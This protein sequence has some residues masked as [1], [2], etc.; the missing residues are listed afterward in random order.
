M[1]KFFTISLFIILITNLTASP[2]NEETARKAALNFLFKYS[3]L[4][5]G[6]IDLINSLVSNYNSTTTYFVF[7]VNGGG[8]IL[9][10]A[11]DA[12]TPVLAYSNSG[13]WN[14]ETVNP[15]AK[16]WIDSYNLEIYNAIKTRAT[17]NE[18]LQE[19]QALLN[20]QFSED[21]PTVSPLLTTQW[22]QSMYYN[23]MCPISSSAPGGYGGRVPTG[24]VATTMAQIMK[25]YNYPTQG[26]GS[27]SYNH[28]AYNTLSANFGST[29]Y[30]WNGMPTAATSSN[31]ALATL[32]FHCGVS[33]QM[34]YDP[35]GSGALSEVVPYAMRTYF[36]YS[37][38]MQLLDKANVGNDEIWRTI[39]KTELEAKRPVYYAG[40][41]TV[42]G[43]AFV[44]D[45]FDASNPTKFHINWGW[46]GSNNGYFAIGALTT[47][48]G[49][50]NEFNRI[51]IGI[52]P[53]TTPG[54]ICRIEN[55]TDGTKVTSG[56]DVAVTLKTI[57]G[58]TT[59]AILY[60]DGIKKDSSITAPFNFTVA[61]GTLAPGVHTLEI[62]ATD[63]IAWDAHESEFNIPSNSW[64]VQNVSFSNDSVRIEQI[65][66]VDENVVWAVIDD[67]SSKDQILRKFI[68][69]TDGGAT[70][71]EGTINCSA[72]S[73][74]E[75]SNIYAFS[76]TKAYACL[77]P[78]N[79]KGGAIVYTEDGGTT[80]T[81]QTTANFTS[82]WANWVYFF[83]TNNGVCMGDSYKPLFSQT[84]NFAVFATSNGGTTWNKV[85]GTNLP[86][87]L[88]SEAGTVNFF[89]AIGNTIWFGTGNGRV[90]KST[91]KGVTWAVKDGGLG[92]VQ[93]NLRFRD[94]NTGFA[95]G[96]FGSANY[97][98]KKTTDG[99]ATWADAKPM[100]TVTGQDYEL[101]PGTDS[102]W[103]NSGYYSSVSLNG[104]KSYFLLDQNTQL[105]TARFFSPLSGWGG[106][107]YSVKGGG[108]IYKWIGN[109]NPK[110]SSKVVIRVKDNNG[111]AVSNA[112]V[113]L[114]YQSKSTSGEGLAIFDVKNL[115]NPETYNISKTGYSSVAANY[116]VNTNDTINV[117][118]SPSYSVTFA[119]KTKLDAPVSGATVLFNGI[120][121]TT[122]ANGN[123]T[124][125]NV[126]KG[127]GYPY[128]VTKIKFYAGYGMLDVK[129]ANSNQNITLITDAT[130][131]KQQEKIS[132]VVFPIPAI[133]VINIMSENPITE[134]EILS[135][136]GKTVLKRSCSSNTVQIPVN[137]LQ[138]G[139]YILKV[140]Q[141]KK[142]EKTKIIVR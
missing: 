112:M 92:A 81:Q 52:K 113:V 67:F 6:N 33:V 115:G 1:K 32:M 58:T 65:F 54:Y 138:T 122:D 82:S 30:N 43:H 107:Y 102:I 76:A 132:H 105:N 71:T 70:W 74:L 39:I 127:L 119:V 44:C 89:D 49:A 45:G 75:I 66:P 118:L 73:S 18:S 142:E 9:I 34:N 136:S 36:N 27:F 79:S 29:D 99:G 129:E 93:T 87:A 37:N 120:S 88:A 139:E 64:Q 111:S 116:L 17:S 123:T 86:V 42:G 2:I 19:W 62:R 11:D 125:T 61:T 55:P 22:D 77:N 20:Q 13:Q 12:A 95:Y 38:S 137:E 7:T 103:I 104:N 94:E 96:G 141:G 69:T 35:K 57:K 114:N 98:F 21:I 28:P 124:F 4:K 48:N 126:P 10:S 8:W 3:R 110:I 24:C 68:K 121:Q 80:W 130:A 14:E 101:I 78:A 51:I 85:T 40:S 46:N 15:T 109:Y 97:S 108:G 140:I 84:Y 72:C 26:V 117:K 23:D 59:K 25:Y 53:R 5:S 16:K 83:D 90:Y 100:G 134:I 131:I 47:S 135:M 63:G 50:F 91:D 56:T 106:G 41:G 133:D 31:T 60:L 128:A